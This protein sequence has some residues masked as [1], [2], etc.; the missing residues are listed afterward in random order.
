MR[1]AENMFGRDVCQAF[2]IVPV[3]LCAF[4]HASQR[5]KNFA[6]LITYNLDY[7]S[8]ILFSSPCNNGTLFTL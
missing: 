1:K 7:K 5:S 4:S 6:V 8:L 2:Q 3:V